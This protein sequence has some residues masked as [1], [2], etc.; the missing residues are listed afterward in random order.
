M[1]PE[2]HQIVDFGPFRLYLQH[3]KLYCGTEELHLG[4]RAM[5]VLLA[6]AKQKGELV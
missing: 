1:S 3:R 6:L 4:G 5:D 2:A